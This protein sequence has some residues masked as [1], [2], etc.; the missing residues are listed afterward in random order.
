[1]PISPPRVDPFVAVKKH[2]YEFGSA[3]THWF[4]ARLGGDP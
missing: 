3:I 4:D 2:Y 1:M